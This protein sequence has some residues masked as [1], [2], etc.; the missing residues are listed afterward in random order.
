MTSR[1]LR[2]REHTGVNSNLLAGDGAS[3]SETLSG[4]SHLSGIGVSV[5]RSGSSARPD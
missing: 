1:A 2:E 3:N 4:M 5:R